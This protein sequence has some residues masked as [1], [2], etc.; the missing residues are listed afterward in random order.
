LQGSKPGPR[1]LQKVGEN[2]LLQLAEFTKQFQNL[3]KF[4][5]TPPQRLKIESFSAKMIT[6]ALEMHDIT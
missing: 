4:R 2:S 6:F 3:Q 1:F 5:F